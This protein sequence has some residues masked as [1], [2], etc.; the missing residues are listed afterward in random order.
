MFKLK[1]IKDNNC[2]GL[3]VEMLLLEVI[4]PGQNR[5]RLFNPLCTPQARASAVSSFLKTMPDH[6]IRNLISND[7]DKRCISQPKAQ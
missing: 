7:F 6:A 1:H 4:T 5:L 2:S 3:P